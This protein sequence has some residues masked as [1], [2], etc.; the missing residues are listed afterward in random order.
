MA[1]VIPPPINGIITAGNIH[2]KYFLVLELISSSP[3]WIETIGWE[4]LSGSVGS[5]GSIGSVGSTGGFE[6]SILFS[7]LNSV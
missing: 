7:N 4:G 1:I 2:A 3:G 5:V 6:L